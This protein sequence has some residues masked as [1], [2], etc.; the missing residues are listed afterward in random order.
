MALIIDDTSLLL[1]LLIVISLTVSLY[2]SSGNQPLIHPL[3][4]SRQAD[5]SK[6]RQPKNSAIYRNA[7][8][9]NGFQLAQKPKPDA[10]DL[11]SLIS[12]GAGANQSN[13]H[14]RHV[15]STL[16]TNAEI[17]GDAA[18]F[19]A[20][21]VKLSA[22]PIRHL[23]LAVCADKDDYDSLI[24]LIASCHRPGGSL[25]SFHTIVVPPESLDTSTAPQTLPRQVSDLG[26]RSISALFTTLSSFKRALNLSLLDPSSLVIL[27][28]EQSVDEAQRVA[29]AHFGGSHRLRIVSVEQVIAAAPTDEVDERAGSEAA[30]DPEA[31]ANSVH[32]FYWT[33]STIWVPVTHKS[34]TAGVVTHMSFFP[35]DKVPAAG[36]HFL[37]ERSENPSTE[38]Q[39]S[40][41]AV[42][43]PAGLA[44]CLVALHTGAGISAVPLSSSSGP[45]SA[46]IEPTLVYCSPTG[47]SDLAR[48]LSD[49]SKQSSLFKAGAKAKLFSIRHGALRKESFWD[50]LVFI[51]ARR[52]A[53]CE[54]IRNLMIVGQGNTVSQSLLDTLRVHLGSPVINAYLPRT[55][56][57]VDGKPRPE[58]VTAP[59]SST[60]PYDL[61][62]FAP[63]V[64]NG[65]EVAAHVGPP[66]VS[67]E[68]KLSET[69]KAKAL[70]YSIEKASK[71]PGQEGD[72]MGEIL[73]R[74]K[75]LCGSD[76]ESDWLATGDI[77][78]FRSNGTL[79]VLRDSAESNIV[80]APGLGLGNAASSLRKRRA[81]A[82][83]PGVAAVSILAA[84]A[85]LSGTCA[86]EMAPS[87]SS[88]SGK[89]AQRLFKRS[90]GLN[91]TLV[92]VAKMGMMGAQRSS[93]G[94][95]VAQSAL[96]ELEH[97]QWSVFAGTKSGPPYRPGREGEAR[98]PPLNV[99]SMAY[100]TIAAQD[101]VGRLGSRISGDENVTEGSSL[102]S[103]S[104]GEGVMLAAWVLGEVADY[105]VSSN[106]FYANAARRQLQ[107]IMNTTPKT[108]DGA[109][110]HRATGLQLWSDGVYMGPPFMA[111][112]GLLTRN[113]TLLREAHNQVRLYREGLLLRTGLSQGLWG[114][115]YS[116]DNGNFSDGGA[117]LTGNGWAAAGMLRVLATLS[118]SENTGDF[119]SEKADL[120]S[121]INEILDA[122]YPFLDR[123]TSLFHNYINETSTFLDPAGSAMIAYSTF[124]I[125]SMHPASGKHVD[126]AER[127]YQ[128]LQRS[129]NPLGY[130]TQDYT[131]VDALAFTVPGPTSAESLSFTLLMESARRDYHASNVTGIDGPGTANGA[132]KERG[133][134]ERRTLM[135][136][137]A[138]L[139]LT[140]LALVAV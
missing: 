96:L 79:V 99:M 16:K 38:S 88:S 137:V 123:D 108:P 98:N 49:I 129:L 42:S 11:P 75:V 66:S 10:F 68:I 73:I 28:R 70:G 12:R 25:N 34:L 120:V 39:R 74:G 71:S 78:S 44:L 62:A 81:A 128:V 43:S 61:Q 35:A 53:R 113:E 59:V 95:G 65:S 126:S 6:V 134:S 102:D 50:N 97:G 51:K 29:S 89:A 14:P 36:D 64:H 90:N 52:V 15:Y 116:V 20:G 109:F 92:D 26:A 41:A 30:K 85:T 37:V 103:A 104:N 119:S 27:P 139:I 47:A 140:L 138:G 87:A 122:A 131:P 115:I 56:S 13:D 33:P 110:S 133:L 93:W 117:W 125:A 83:S 77:G 19:A 54:R 55:L 2:L 63:Y 127:I 4:L 60:H 32:S 135:A 17:A 105:T 100:H 9:P 114:H 101:G 121:W 94:N 48:A 18:A 69:P 111:Y 106:G 67:I 76:K 136:S 91:N 31:S 46:Y 72:P 3:I 86:I 8:T 84:V 7:N 5:V 107:Y 24:A 130:Y 112:Y 45:S 40:L 57:S 22:I 58:L 21:L 132:G 80:S 1:L 124:R 82:A 118:Q 23:T